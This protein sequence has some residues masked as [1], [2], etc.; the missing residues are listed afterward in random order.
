MRILLYTGKGGV[1]KTT[2][3]AATAVRAAE[4][5][6][7][8]MVMSTDLAHS[9]ADSLDVAVGPEPTQIAPNLWAQETDIYHNL[10]NYW[11]RIQDWLAAVLAWRQVD[12]LVADELSVLPGMEELANL[13]W[14]NRHRESGNY[15]L[16]VVDCAP[17]GE[18][19]R[20]L[21]FPEVGRWWVEKLLPIQRAAAQ[22][23]RPLVRMATGMPMPENEVYDA[24]ED[25]FGQLDTLH[26]M[27]VDPTLT[28]MRLVVNPEKMVIKEAQRTYTYLNL[29]GYPTDL[30]VCNR[31]LPASINDVY[32]DRW[33]EMQTEYRRMIQE[34]FTP[35]PVRE[36]PL[37]REEVVGMERLA[38]MGRALFEEHDPTEHFFQ[39][40]PQRI[41]KSDGE[42][43]LAI[44]LPFTDK[45]DIQLLRLGD[46]LVVHVGPH[47][48][49]IVLP[50]LLAALPQ[51]GARFE[52]DTLKVRF[53]R[54]TVASRK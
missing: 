26:R 29:F 17:T 51:I 36:V 52:G 41:E 5:G 19:I 4:M 38:E 18:T 39:G 7:R 31:V 49:N 42:F 6:Q 10:R 27:L 45:R 3:A 46:E 33:K 50:R 21:S 34:G 15:D 40:L 2:V 54:E 13:L 1:G 43:V 32:F 12:E 20:L 37:F 16:V 53:A 30:V 24:V 23:V 9:L 47:K 44:P 48:R 25:L 35:T 14:I 22:M 28:S 8:T 11:G